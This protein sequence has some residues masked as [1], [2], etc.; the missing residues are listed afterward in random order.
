MVMLA[1]GDVPSIATTALLATLFL[2]FTLLGRDSE[3]TAVAEDQETFDV[4]AGRR[5]LTRARRGPSRQRPGARAQSTFAR[6]RGRRAPDGGRSRRRGHDGS[7]AWRGRAGRCLEPTRHPRRRKNGCCRTCSPSQ[8]G[9]AD[10]YACSS[11]RPATSSTPSSRRR[12]SSGPPRCTSASR[13]RSP[14]RSRHGCSAT[15][16]SARSS[17]NRWTCDS[18]ILHRS[19]R[20]DTYHLGAHA[21]SLA[22]GDLDL[23]HRVWLLARQGHWTTRPSSRRRQG[24]PHANGTTTQRT[25]S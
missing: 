23:I 13:R 22:P 25:Q 10:L 21:P 20:S 16:G 3:S 7:A 19:G 5:A 8:S 9:L 17:L 1:T 6:A 24:S 2:L 18:V 4:A 12:C 15:R 14:P 11:F